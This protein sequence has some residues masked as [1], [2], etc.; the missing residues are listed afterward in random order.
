M[1]DSASGTE[2]GSKEKPFK[3]IKDALEKA[4]KKGGSQEIFINKGKYEESFTIGESIELRGEDEGEVKITGT[5]TMKDGS[6][7]EDLTIG[8]ENFAIVVKAEADVEIENCTIEDFGKVG[9]QSEVGGGKITV[10]GSK[11]R[12]GEGKGFYLQK[13]REVLISGNDVYDNGEEGIDIRENVDGKIQNNIIRENGESGIELV[14]GKADLKITNNNIKYNGSSGIATQFYSEIDDEGD[15]D[16]EKND[17]YGNEKYGLDCNI[18]QG[19]G[20]GASYW[21]NSI[22]MIDNNVAKNKMGAINSRC[23]FKI[24]KVTEKEGLD[25]EK[26]DGLVE[27]ESKQEEQK[28]EEEKLAEKKAEEE[29]LFRE[30]NERRIREVKNKIS[31]EEKSINSIENSV[32]KIKESN[33]LKL[34][35][36]GPKKNEIDELFLL[37]E[38]EE[39]HLSETKKMLK[40]I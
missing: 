1:D 17:L 14:V 9:I 12:D 6:S 35:F 25:N 39:T 27:E 22:E 33:K 23:N 13:G 7:I 10:T 36:F 30:E 19:G 3:K 24:E 20:Y 37:L 38:K 34:F 40:E 16:I 28:S 21:S 26:G 32:N 5:V 2:D 18:P 29:R 11:I 8:G 4:V 15:I 31:E